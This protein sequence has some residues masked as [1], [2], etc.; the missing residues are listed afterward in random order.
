MN[1]SAG[2]GCGC[3]PAP[4]F[5][6]HTGCTLELMAFVT[7]ESADRTRWIWGQGRNRWAADLDVCWNLRSRTSHCWRKKQKQRCHSK[8]YFK[9]CSGVALFWDCVPY[10]CR[11]VRL[12]STAHPQSSEQFALPAVQNLPHS[13][14]CSWSLDVVGS[15]D[16]CTGWPGELLPLGSCKWWLSR[17]NMFVRSLSQKH[18][19]S[20]S[21]AHKRR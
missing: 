2:W 7:A 14:S 12:Y 9:R 8:R 21:S 1:T 19:Q 18:K 6:L 3:P 10:L 11:S 15:R 20:S 16:G 17:E 13:G 4:I 5:A